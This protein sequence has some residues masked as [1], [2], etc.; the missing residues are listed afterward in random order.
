M[1]RPGIQ[2]HLTDEELIELQTIL[3]NTD[4]DP[5]LKERAGI[6]IDW[7]EGKTYDE[8]Q[9][10]RQVSRNIVAKWRQRY[11]TKRLEGLSDAYR[12]GKPVVITEEQKNRV[13]HLAGSNPEK[14]RKKWSQHRIVKEV[15]ISASKVNK[16]L[17]EQDKKPPKT[18]Y[19]WS[20]KSSDPEFEP[21]M[22][23]IIGLYLNPPQ[24]V[25]VLCVDEKTK[26]RALDRAQGE[27]PLRRSVPEKSTATDKKNRMVNLVASL[28]VHKEEGLAETAG[29]NNVDNS[30]KFLKKLISRHKGKKLHIIA[31]NLAG[32]KHEI[33]KEWAA[34]NKKL[35]LHYT[36]TYSSWLNLVEI[37]FN[38]LSKD[39]L[40]GTVWYSK[41]QLIEQLM[42]YVKAYNA[43]QEKPFSWTYSTK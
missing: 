4:V 13:I 19:Y 7:H 12:S 27:Q 40:K 3:R 1:S 16:I 42:E 36:P 20:G 39:V 31:D 28:A 14:G 6:I 33:I 43:E 11:L 10:L 26:I 38:I 32:H 29:N 9:L 8:S 22:L 18:A 30:L 35:E 17:R 15:G 23:D 34:K 2:V 21:K 41:Q 25:L 5:R 37:W 24:N